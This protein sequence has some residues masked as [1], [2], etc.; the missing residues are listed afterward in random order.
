MAISTSHLFVFLSIA[1]IFAPSALAT[2]YTVGDD[3]GW[4]VGVNYTEWAQNKTFYV[5]DNLSKSFFKYFQNINKLIFVS[6]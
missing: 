3:A 1:A 5:G 4:K 2:N 6:K